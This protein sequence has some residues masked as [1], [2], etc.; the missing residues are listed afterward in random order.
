MIKPDIIVFNDVEYKSVRPYEASDL[1]LGCHFE[2]PEH[3]EVCG[4]AK[5]SPKERADGQNVIYKPYI[6]L[7]IKQ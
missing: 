2:K 1:C 3:L 6:K 4:F 7:R 5:C